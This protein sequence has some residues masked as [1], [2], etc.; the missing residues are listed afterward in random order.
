MGVASPTSTGL[1]HLLA[2]S[3]IP[4]RQVSLSNPH[5]GIFSRPPFTIGRRGNE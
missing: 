1:L 2:A 3:C 4:S 5:C